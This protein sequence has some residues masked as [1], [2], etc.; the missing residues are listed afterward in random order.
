[1]VAL[2]LLTTLPEHL[3]NC[4]A[5]E[6]HAILGGPTLIHL[7]GKQAAPLFVSILLH[8]NETTG[9][10]AV[11]ALLKSKASLPRDLIIF[12]GNTAAAE[13]GARRLK[14]Q[15]DYNRIWAGG[16][17][18]EHRLA[19]QV[20][21]YVANT[22][23]VAAVDIHNNTGRNPL[24]ACI[25]HVDRRF[26]SLAQSFSNTIVFFSEPHQVLANNMARYCPAVTLECGL[27][28][29]PSGIEQAIATLEFGLYG[30]LDVATS[31]LE[32]CSV[33]HTVARMRVPADSSIHFADS[34]SSADFTL[35]MSLDNWNF[36]RLKPNTHFAYCNSEHAT[37]S[38][39]NDA[40]R[41][42]T[43][44]Y[45]YRDGNRLFTRRPFIPSMLTL[46]EKVIQQDCVGYIMEPYPLA[47]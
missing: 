9:L 38:V 26:V 28:G 36:T 40:G 31:E 22:G 2:S 35:P 20:L 8:G 15:P 16:E 42:V 13:K 7:K 19:Q 11:Q 45:F 5:T 32:D 3:L 27:A 24:Y 30:D 43:G 37:L 44:E 33:F 23:P 14:N 18:A 41:D 34:P 6:L 12:V 25:N 1:M 10:P 46:D 29:E 47:G 21:D 17:L 39:S 4:R